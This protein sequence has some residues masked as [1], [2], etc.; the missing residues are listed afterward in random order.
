MSQHDGVLDNAPGQAFRLDVQAAIQALLTQ[1]SGTTEPGT[2]GFAPGA[3]T[4]SGGLNGTVTTTIGP[5]SDS[6]K[7]QAYVVMARV[8]NLAG[9]REAP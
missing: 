5:Y 8:N 9:Q 6:Y 2:M 7:R 4:Y 3:R 1:N